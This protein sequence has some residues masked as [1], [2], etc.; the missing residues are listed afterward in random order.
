[1]RGGFIVVEGLDFA[2]KTTVAGLL[3][4][5]LAA[6]GRPALTNTAKARRLRR[7]SKALAASERVPVLVPDLLFIAAVLHDT[8]RIAR[9]RRRGVTVVQDRYYPSYVWNQLAMPR[10]RWSSTLP[11][12]R[13]LRPLFLEPDLVIHC[14]CSPGT[15]RERYD[16]KRRTASGELSPNDLAVFSEDGAERIERFDRAFADALA[17]ARALVRIDNDGTLEELRA[18]VVAVVGGRGHPPL[19]VPRAIRD[20]NYGQASLERSGET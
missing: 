19:G 1:M 15:L 2:G 20:A 5:E 17:D 16:A 18:A 11:L 8:A 7:W 9:L 12:Y 4:E 14:R 10:R 3:I 13:L 6:G